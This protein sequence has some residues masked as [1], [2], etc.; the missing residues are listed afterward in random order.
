MAVLWVLF[1]IIVLFCFWDLP[2]L[3]RKAR[4]D[5][6]RK[7]VDYCYRQRSTR[8]DSMMPPSAVTSAATHNATTN[9]NAHNVNTDPDDTV[10]YP[11]QPPDW[12]NTSGPSDESK[13]IPVDTL[14]SS[15]EIIETAERLMSSSYEDSGRQLSR[16]Y[17]RGSL[18]DLGTFDPEHFALE[19]EDDAMPMFDADGQVGLLFQSFCLQVVKN[20]I[21][22]DVH[23]L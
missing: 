8:Y 11:P 14:T 20:N 17:P 16:E 3:Q 18:Y 4:E 5:L 21:S 9:I 23:F 19:E 15:N 22:K 6:I 7:E 13:L 1:E 12:P 2:K 10:V